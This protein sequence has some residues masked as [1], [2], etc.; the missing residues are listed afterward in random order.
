MKESLA[1]LK[2]RRE[3]IMRLMSYTA[4]RAGVEGTVTMYQRIQAAL[5]S[6]IGE[7]KP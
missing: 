5:A 3:Y 1:S 4:G 2:S 7:P 6:E